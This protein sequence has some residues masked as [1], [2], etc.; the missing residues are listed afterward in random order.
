MKTRLWWCLWWGLDLGG[1]FCVG[2]RNL[3]SREDVFTFNLL[4]QDILEML[5]SNVT[6]KVDATIHCITVKQKKK[7]IPRSFDGLR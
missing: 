6:C 4:C 3:A 7:L 5:Y 2:D 1:R